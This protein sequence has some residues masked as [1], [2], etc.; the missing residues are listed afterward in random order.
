MVNSGTSCSTSQECGMMALCVENPDKNDEKVCALKQ[1]SLVNTRKNC[2]KDI[3]A[4]LLKS[5]IP[6][7]DIDTKID[8]ALDGKL[9]SKFKIPKGWNSGDGSKYAC[10]LHEDDKSCCTLM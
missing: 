10:Y 3:R 5:G 1:L 4:A 2:L 7:S 6:E 8:D 9:I